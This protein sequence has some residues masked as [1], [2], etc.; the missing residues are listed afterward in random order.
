MAEQQRTRVTDNAD[1][2]R[3]EIFLDDTL[4][5]FATYRDR[6]G[7]RIV[8]HSEVSPE[9]EHHG[10]AS[11]LARAALDDIRSRGMHVVPR[12]PFF[13]RYIAEHDDFADL[14]AT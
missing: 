13:A 11:E 14:V 7:T 5:G 4:A 12:C 1:L 8:L 9:F 3:Y 10:L 6:P 2:H